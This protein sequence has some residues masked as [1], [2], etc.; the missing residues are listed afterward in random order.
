MNYALH[1]MAMAM[2]KRATPG[3]DC[4]QRERTAG[5]THQEAMRCLK[6]RLADVFRI[7]GP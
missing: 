5:K 1:V 3:R 6:R 7:G 4:Y 2:V